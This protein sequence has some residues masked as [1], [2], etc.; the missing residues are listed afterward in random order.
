[1]G[2]KT[3]IILAQEFTSDLDLKER[4]KIFSKDTHVLFSREDIQ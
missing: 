1:M 2:S 4:V 3:E